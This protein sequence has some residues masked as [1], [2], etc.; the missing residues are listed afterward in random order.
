M[1]NSVLVIGGGISGIRAAADLG[2]LGVKTFLVERSEK[3]GG[4]FLKL[5]KT[6]PY[7]TNAKDLLD[8]QIQILK[9]LQNVDIHTRTRVKSILRENNIFK[10]T[11]TPRDTTLE[12]GALIVATG[13]EPINATNISNYG[14]GKYKNVITS[15]ELLEIIGNNQECIRPSDQKQPKSISF[16]Q[17]IGSRDKKTNEYCSSFCCTY[18]VH[19]ANIIK[20]FDPSIEITIFY[21]DMRTF[22]NYESLFQEARASGVKFLRGK[23]AMVLEEVETNNLIIEVENTVSRDFLQHKTDMIV[24]SIG[25]EPAN[26][27]DVL[28]ET[29]GVKLD[30]RT[31]F[32]LI[33]E[34]DD[35]SAVGNDRIFV[36]GNA[37]G[38]KD[39]QYSLS[40]AS[41][42]AMK[43]LI[44]LGGK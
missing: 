17:C 28:S 1:T 21:M 2:Q 39:S 34:E 18:A 38:P 9:S 37:S 41:A 36:I 8:N 40:Q 44:T 32:F 22:S 29:L 4:I 20:E 15:L 12:V 5:G 13:F 26:E 6:F 19:I 30:D 23:P 3:L 33:N 42:A 31:G 10:V 16:I 14:Y 24:L 27:T 43:V 7:G 35:I 25:A 11:L